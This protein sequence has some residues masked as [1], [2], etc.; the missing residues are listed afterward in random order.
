PA[1][2]LLL[3]AAQGGRAV[4]AATVYGVSLVALFGVSALYHRVTWSLSARRWMGR[5]DHA[6]IN[7][8]IAG[9]FTPLGLLV[10]SGTLATAV[11]GRRGG[12]HPPPRPLD[13]RAEAA[14][15]APLPPPRLERHGR[16]PAGRVGDRLGADRA[17]GPRRRALFRGGGRVRAAPA[18]PGARRVRLPR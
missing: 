5:L 17:P 6:M 14:E 1:L 4:L 10:L 15:R 3:V 18:Q 2:A 12:G 16:R 11:L 8:L 7:V 13:R 9:S